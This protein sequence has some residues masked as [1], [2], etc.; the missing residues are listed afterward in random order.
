LK[1]CFTSSAEL[2]IILSLLQLVLQGSDLPIRNGRE[3]QIENLFYIFCRIDN[4]SQPFTAEGF[5]FGN[6]NRAG[7][8]YSPVF[9]Y[10]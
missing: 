9:T 10:I 3:K 4:H 2:T 1:I 7:G 8:L 5:G 6:P